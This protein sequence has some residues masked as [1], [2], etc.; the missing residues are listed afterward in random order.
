MRKKKVKHAVINIH[1]NPTGCSSV[2]H[3]MW[4]IEFSSS[5]DALFLREGVRHAGSLAGAPPP[6][7]PHKD[8]GFRSWPESV[9]LM[10]LSFVRRFLLSSFSSSSIVYGPVQSRSRQ[11]H[12][13]SGCTRSFLR[14]DRN[15]SLSISITAL[16]CGNHAWLHEDSFVIATKLLKDSTVSTALWHLHKHQ[17]DWTIFFDDFLIVRLLMSHHIIITVL[18]PQHCFA[19]CKIRYYL[20]F[21][22]TGFPL[23]QESSWL[24]YDSFP[25][26]TPKYQ[27]KW[28]HSLTL[29]S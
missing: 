2:S 7:H 12:L 21:L 17:V 13:H 10:F 28:K 3:V 9:A 15:F 19:I 26:P 29:K 22:I 24:G 20:V 18:W 25:A 5:P 14:H 4:R 23:T 11:N 6:L 1:T 16:I 27:G 8:S